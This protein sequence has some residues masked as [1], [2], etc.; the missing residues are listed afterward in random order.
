MGKGV[1]YIIQQ[2]VVLNLGVALANTGGNVAVG[3]ASQNQAGV[4]QLAAGWTTPG[5]VT[6][7][8]AVATNQSN[9]LAR[10]TT[11]VATATGNSATTTV[12][13]MV[14]ILGGDSPA[15]FVLIQQGFVHNIG[16]AVANTGGNVA[17]GNQS[18]N[19]AGVHQEAV[20][21]GEGAVLDATATNT[22]DGTAIIDTGVPPEVTP[23]VV[24]PTPVPV[25]AELPDT[26][27][28]PAPA[29]EVSAAE[30]VAVSGTLPYTG[31][32]FTDEGVAAGVLLLLAGF[33][34]QRRSRR[35]AT[36]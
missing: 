6:S 8:T 25:P 18:T 3:N 28:A 13:Q 26:S 30:A 15:P 4:T 10:I 14:S 32:D 31:S 23:P 22:S 27:V 35:R 21:S 11:G 36:R 17:I 20:G 24:V 1:L 19:D 16:L 9:G 2:S 33:E 12:I 5:S 7:V 34:L 29:P